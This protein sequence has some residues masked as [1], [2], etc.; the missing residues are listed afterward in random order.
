MMLC[1]VFMAIVLLIAL[2][3]VLDEVD[4][5]YIA[6]AVVRFLRKF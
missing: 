6:R 2:G 5:K 3:F 4:I 1:G